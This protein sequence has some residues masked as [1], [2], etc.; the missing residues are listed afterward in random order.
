MLAVG[1]VTGVLGSRAASAAPQ[2][3]AVTRHRGAYTLTARPAL[4]T[5][6]HGLSQAV[7]CATR[8]PQPAF[9]QNE[10]AENGVNADLR[11]GI[12]ARL[13][14]A[15]NYLNS[16]NHAQFAD[17]LAQAFVLL[18]YPNEGNLTQCRIWKTRREQIVN[19]VENGLSLMQN[20]QSTLRA[21]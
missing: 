5:E 4:L 11:A 17:S 8:L 2:A 19:R 12:Q 16:G 10:I 18:Y 1:C 21:E 7:A 14:E 20:L 15:A 3:Q 9:S 6:L 13:A